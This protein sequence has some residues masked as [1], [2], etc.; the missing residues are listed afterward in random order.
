MKKLILTIALFLTSYYIFANTIY[1]PT[2]VAPTDVAINQMPNVLLDWGA[3][4]GAVSYK[5]EIDTSASFTNS[6]FYTTNVTA[7]NAVDLLFGT[8]Y[9]WRV[10][11]IGFTDSSAWSAAR[12]FTTI[13]TFT[14][15]SPGDSCW[16]AGPGQL[17]KW[18]TSVT[19]C[20]FFDIEA[21]TTTNFNSSLH[22]IFPVS[23]T[24]HQGNVSQLHYGLRYYWRV[25]GRHSKDTT[26]WTLVRSMNIM[27]TVKLKTPND[28][29]INQV[30]NI[31]LKWE[32][33]VGNQVFQYETDT[34]LLFNSSALS[35]LYTV[36]SIKR[37]DTLLFGT[38]YYWRVRSMHAIDTSGWAIPR[39]FTTVDI[40]TL[41]TPANA[42]IGVATSPTLKWTSIIGITG[43]ELEMDTLNTFTHPHIYYPGATDNQIIITG[44]VNAQTYYWRLR[45]ISSR[46]T[47]SWS[48]TWSFTVIGVGI[49]DISTNNANVSIFPNPANDKTTISIESRVNSLIN[50]ELMNILGKTV[51]KEYMNLSIGSNTKE[52]NLEGLSK[53]IYFIK[54]SNNKNTIVR[55]LTVR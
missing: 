1:A 37:A 49:N 55:K 54:L 29:V 42:S 20:T 31:E 45:A 7:I 17:V 47:S 6:I 2:L 51:R 44:L 25:R 40:L 18:Q 34:T 4:A 23:G 22:A 3:A 52:L 38:K 5:I 19:G 27:D 13:S 9:Y 35:S 24:L 43:Y 10:K 46:D 26:N 32:K 53:G 30:P 28:L 15:V 11:T 16:H 36:D 12:S 48:A 8:T 39:S 50:I 14:L 21:D 33:V 41:T